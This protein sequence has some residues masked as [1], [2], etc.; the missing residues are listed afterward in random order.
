MLR[1]LAIFLIRLLQPTATRLQ[2]DFEPNALLLRLLRR[3]PLRL[4]LFPQLR[5]L[6]LQRGTVV[7]QPS[8]ALRQLRGGLCQRLL[9]GLTSRLLLRHPL[10]ER[11]DLLRRLAIFLIRLLQP[12]THC[13][14]LAVQSGEFFLCRLQRL[15][16]C[17]AGR[18]FLLG[19]LCQTGDLFSGSLELMI[20]LFQPGTS[21]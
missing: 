4:P 16:S 19:L 2:L 1:R 3:D 20:R 5:N 11:A 10:L 15:L 14:Q 7:L 9:G 12:T 17:F 6:L 21:L 8:L 18:L 13:H